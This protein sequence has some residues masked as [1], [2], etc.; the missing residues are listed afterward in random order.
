MTSSGW[1]ADQIRDEELGLKRGGGICKRLVELLGNLFHN[2]YITQYLIEASHLAHPSNKVVK[3]ALRAIGNIVCAEEEI[4]YT[5]LI[6]EAGVLPHLKKLILSDSKDIQ[7]EACWTL[8]NIAA[9]STDQIDKVFALDVVG[10]LGIKF[11]LTVFTIINMHDL[12]FPVSL[13]KSTSADLE[14]RLEASWFILNATSCGTDEQIQYMIDQ[15]SVSVL[16]LMLS[17]TTMV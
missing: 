12:C 11:L 13:A 7:K 9:G 14:V 15:G 8:S 1:T 5:P 2:I 3:P 6:I 17:D 4:D 10:T 16:G